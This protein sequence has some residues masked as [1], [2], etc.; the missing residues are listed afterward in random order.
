M[1]V[2]DA[3]YVGEITIKVKPTLIVYNKP[4]HT[5]ANVMPVYPKVY[6]VGERI[7]QI[8]IEKVHDVVFNEVESLPETER[9]TGG[10][11]SSGK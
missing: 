9:G 4:V 10:Y 1:G 11:G 6:R 8:S 3:G 7:A 2:I 5:G